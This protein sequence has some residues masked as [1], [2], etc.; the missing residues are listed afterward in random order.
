MEIYATL[1]YNK[2][3]KTAGD[4]FTTLHPARLGW[5]QCGAAH[6]WIVNTAGLRRRSGHL[7]CEA[8]HA[9]QLIDTVKFITNSFKQHVE[10]RHWILHNQN[11]RQMACNQ[12]QSFIHN[13]SYSYVFTLLVQS[14]KVKICQNVWCIVFMLFIIDAWIRPT[15]CD[16][17]CKSLVILLMEEILLT[18]W[19]V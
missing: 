6:F 19:D 11:K 1:W 12:L 7:C 3:T 18:T 14:W 9:W 10:D 5:P 2:T 17:L 8:R 16:I 4:F 15:F 13:H